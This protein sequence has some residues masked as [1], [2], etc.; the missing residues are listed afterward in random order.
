MPKLIIGNV[1]SEAVVGDVSRLPLFTRQAATVYAKRLALM[2]EENDI[3]ILPLAISKIMIDYISRKMENKITAINFF[4]ISK[5]IDHPIVLTSDILLNDELI[6]KIKVLVSGNQWILFPYIYSSAVISF[7][8]ELDVMGLNK[9]MISF[10]S[11]YGVNLLN[12]KASFRALSA[13]YVSI[14]PG[15]ICKTPQELHYLMRKQIKNLGAIIVKKDFSADGVGNIAI[16][17]NERSECAGVHEVIKLNSYDELTIEFS[18]T[19][20]DK[21]V[22]SLGNN[23]IVVETYF[24]SNNT[25]YAE[26]NIGKNLSDCKLL[27]YGLVRMDEIEDATGKGMVNWIGF[28]IPCNLPNNISEEFLSGCNKLMQLV[29][30]LGYEGLINFD[31]IVTREN[32]ILFTEINGRLGGCSHIQS[33][34]EKLIGPDY[35][36]THCILTRNHVPV[37]DLNYAISLAESLSTK[38]LKGIVIMNEDIER[39]GVIDYLVYAKLEKDALCL[40]NKFLKLV[41]KDLP[42]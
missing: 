5:S 35:L 24:P 18:N 40:E 33:I 36:R 3:L 29:F 2:L 12:S 25:L 16:I 6:Q 1:F 19:L 34:G 7:F 41:I 37:T 38:D 27:N 10:V 20:W 28:Q 17:L 9:E 14:P 11:Q 26:Y 30:S 4:P 39:W 23:L 32:K 31:A 15:G 42:G 21:F 22:D 13:Q 8:N